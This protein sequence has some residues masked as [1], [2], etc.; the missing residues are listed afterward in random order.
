MKNFRDFD[1]TLVSENQAGLITND[2]SNPTDFDQTSTS[3]GFLIAKEEDGERSSLIKEVENLN[4]DDIPWNEMKTKQLIK[5]FFNISTSSLL[6]SCSYFSSLILLLIN[7]HFIGLSSDPVLISAVGLGNMWINSIGINTIYGMNYGFEVMASKAYGA[8][9]YRQVGI[10]FKKALIMVF[11]VF[12]CFA[13]ISSVTNPLFLFLGQSEAV[14][15]KLSEYVIGILP[16]FLFTGLFDLRSLYF[17]AQEIFLPPILIQLFTTAGHVGWCIYFINMGLDVQGIAFA[18]DITLFCNFICLEFYNLC[19][20][21]L[22]ESRAPWCRE[23]FKDFNEYLAITVPIAMTTVLEE[24]SYEVNSIFAGLLN[25]SILAAHVA[26]ANSGS[27]FY[28]LPEGFCTGINTY[29]GIS[30]GE[31][32]KNK[33][34]RFAI[35]G[36]LGGI[37]ILIVCYLLL[38]IFKDQWALF[39]TDEPNVDKLMIDTLG[40]FVIMGMVDTFQ[41]CLGAILKVTGRGKFALI[42]YFMCLYVV[43]N[44]MSFI[45]G[46]VLGWEL[47]G[48]WFG[49]ICGVTLLGICFLVITV[50]INWQKEI[51]MVDENEDVREIMEGKN[52]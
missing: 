8:E 32:K 44:P 4:E 5:D 30:I 35:L 17:N 3:E 13:T 18:M 50:K 48:I 10:C 23:V 7:L 9:N 16:A 42:M 36:V 46:N 39:F 38:Y 29:V 25:E 41:L 43:A 51:D 45:F 26:M 52:K 33:A 15:E 22:K 40:L 37:M 49:I 6:I 28:C 47:K 24:F 31:K 34:K 12:F 27:L 11:I 1:S 2:I 14:C 21:P 19:W 20:S